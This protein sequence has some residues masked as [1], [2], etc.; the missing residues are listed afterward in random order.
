MPTDATMN[1][2]GG[3][4]SA[5]ALRSGFAEAVSHQRDAAKAP[6]ATALPAPVRPPRRVLP[7]LGQLVLRLNEA[8]YRAL[9][10]DMRVQ[11]ARA[12]CVDRHAYSQH[13]RV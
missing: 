9:A 13:R 7:G 5:D 2:E 1:H 3:I 10:I 8:R 11:A 4:Y 12:R 6:R